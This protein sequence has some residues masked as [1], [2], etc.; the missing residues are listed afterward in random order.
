MARLLEFLVLSTEGPNEK[1]WGWLIHVVVWTPQ[2]IWGLVAIGIFVRITRT[3]SVRRT[4]RCAILL[5]YGMIAAAIGL[6][7]KTFGIPPFSPTG[8][9]LGPHYRDFWD[10]AM[11]SVVLLVGVV[12]LNLY[13][14]FSHSEQLPRS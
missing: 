2:V 4:S 10:C 14:F 11:P 3:W 8:G 9:Y 5:P 7:M 12:S 1:A 6:Q 13:W